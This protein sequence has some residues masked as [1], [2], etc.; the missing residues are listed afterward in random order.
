MGDKVIKELK[1]GI[2]DSVVINDNP[3]SVD[4]IDW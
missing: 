3:V 2:V 1:N 4:E